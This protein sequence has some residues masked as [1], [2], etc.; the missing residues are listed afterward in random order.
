M[1]FAA[2]S[3]YNGR[4]LKYFLR[5]KSGWGIIIL[6]KAGRFPSPFS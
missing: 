5:I 2:V 4:F 3:R 1:I 6:E